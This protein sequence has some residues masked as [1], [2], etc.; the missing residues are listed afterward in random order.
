[1]DSIS[2]VRAGLCLLALLLGACGGSEAPSGGGAA[3]NG[4]PP[5]APPTTTITERGYL[6]MRDGVQL[7]YVIE[8]PDGPGPY[9]AVLNYD[10]YSAGDA[11]TSS[12]QTS[13]HDELLAD[14]YAFVGVNVRGSGC[15]GGTFIVFD[16]A[17][18]TDGHDVVEWIAAQP[19]SN[20]RVGMYGVSFP[21]I[22]QWMVGGMRPPHLAS[23]IPASTIS[24]SYR[25]VGYPGGIAN[26]GF[27]FLW[28]G[29]QNESAAQAVQQASARGD[30][31]CLEHYTNS[32]AQNPPDSVIALSLQHPYQDELS[33]TNAPGRYMPQVQ[34]PALVFSQWQDEQVMSGVT[35][36]FGELDPA[37]TWIVTSNGGHAFPAECPDCLDMAER[38]LRWTLNGD[39]T[40]FEQFPH[41]RMFLDTEKTADYSAME[42]VVRHGFELD[43]PSWASAEPAPM[44]YYLRSGNALQAE[45]P[46]TAE[47]A[48][49]Y[50]YP[51]AS[52]SAN[53]DG[54]AS[55]YAPT[56]PWQL[57]APGPGA[58]SYTSDPFTEGQVLFKA[59]ADL[60]LSSTVADT[61][62]QV[63]LTEV[64]PDGQEM[65]IQRGWLRASHRTLDE[66]RSTALEPW[67]T[68]RAEDSQSL[69]PGEPALLRVGLFPFT[70]L[71]RVGSRLRLIVD[72]PT[73]STGYW[74]LQFLDTPAVNQVLHD[75]EHP[76]RLVVGSLPIPPGSVVPPLAAC[77]TL[78]NQACRP[79]L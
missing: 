25:D 41:V 24:H 46:A 53:T 15:S 72:A 39:D 78:Y 40:Q 4:E 73:G 9:P 13:L 22:T 26:V 60:W 51:L 28:Y 48:D 50:P 57:T 5:Q 10:G 62:L 1:M 59:S 79:S 67:H 61:D 43:F 21:G 37:Q 56:N 74:V 12:A 77:G 66:S 20:G 42:F 58:V 35:R 63:T 47:P 16:P 36:L 8:R 14:G 2:A 33:D 32:S 19:W 34:V 3:G 75:A 69:V 71:M 54:T 29:L 7:A 31:Q 52:A 76:S 65:Y 70:H 11:P 55:G 44:S 18:A 64:R 49:S 27:P 17:W 6:A 68:H 38:F 30:A 45:P 23:I